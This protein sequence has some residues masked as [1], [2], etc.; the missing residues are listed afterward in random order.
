MAWRWPD[1]SRSGLITGANVRSFEAMLLGHEPLNFMERHVLL[2][3]VA[4]DGRPI[5]I[6]LFRH[7][8]PVST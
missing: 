6:P 5:F 4:N 2:F 1:T 8:E 3:V 7:G